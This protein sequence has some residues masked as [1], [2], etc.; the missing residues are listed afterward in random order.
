MITSKTKL[1]HKIGKSCEEGENEPLSKVL[2]G[3][4]RVQEMERGVNHKMAPI[5]GGGGKKLAK[6]IAK[7]RM[8]NTHN[9]THVGNTKNNTSNPVL[10]A[11][12]SDLLISPHLIITINWLVFANHSL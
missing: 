9:H 7:L 11:E 8:P 10:L 1:D 4:A 12:F 2:V 3:C 6:K 5:K